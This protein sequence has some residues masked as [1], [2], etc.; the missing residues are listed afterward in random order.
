MTTKPSDFEEGDER[1]LLKDWTWE[2]D[3]SALDAAS[4][5][6]ARV[7]LDQIKQDCQMYLV[8]R[9]GT[10]EATVNLFGEYFVT[11]DI[12]QDLTELTDQNFW[13]GGRKLWET[14]IAPQEMLADY[15]QSVADKIRSE[16]ATERA[17]GTLDAE[18]GM[19]YDEWI[20]SQ[21]DAPPE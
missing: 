8:A 17:R 14:E 18:H 3:T 1:D 5:N 7:L 20:A 21:P 11:F 19:P 15:F 10:V 6:G 13:R 4:V 16:A 2:N 9:N 12:T